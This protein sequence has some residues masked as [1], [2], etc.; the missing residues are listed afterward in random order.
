MLS[1]RF[2]DS[3]R[4]QCR[5]VAA[6]VA[7][8]LA[9]VAVVAVACDSGLEPSPFVGISGVVTLE[10]TAPDSTEWVRLIVLRERPDSAEDFLDVSRLLA[11]LAAFT[12]PLPLD[13][14]EY[15]FHVELA[16]GEY[17][18]LLAVWKKLGDLDSTTLRE[19]GTYYGEKA[20]SEGPDTITVTA[21]EE[22]AGLDF[23]A[24]LDSLRSIHD[25]FPPDSAGP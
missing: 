23:V 1:I 19:A 15:P 7:A 25:L 8:A 21:G 3:A 12:D 5:R 14:P 2:A 9:A 16:P 4:S 13:V 22:T 6:R 18:W 20:P 17:A 10:G 24:N 11:N